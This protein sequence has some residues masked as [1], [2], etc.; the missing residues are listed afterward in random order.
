[1]VE[2]TAAGRTL[3]EHAAGSLDSEMRHHLVALPADT[4]TQVAQSLTRLTRRE[5]G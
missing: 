3:L 4:V 5:R 1:M 2:L